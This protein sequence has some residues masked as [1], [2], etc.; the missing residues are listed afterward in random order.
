M[1]FTD[2]TIPTSID[3]T[4]EAASASAAEH[5]KATQAT[6]LKLRAA[7]LGDLDER[8]RLLPAHPLNQRPVKILTQS[9]RDTFL[10][11]CE[12]LV[13]KRPGYCFT[14]DYRVGKS[15]ALL[16]IKEK[17]PQSLPQV[18]V[19]LVSAQDHERVTERVLWGDILTA[20]KLITTGTAQ[21]RQKRLRSAIIG[22]CVQA[23]GNQFALL[24][25]ESQ[26][27]KEREFTCLR[28]LANQL[29]DEDG[30]TLTTVCLGDPR[31]SELSRAFRKTRKDLWARFLM[32]PERFYG[33]RDLT[34]LRFFLAEHDNTKRCEYP[35]G[36]G[37]SY[38]E[39]FLP[40]AYANGWR[41]EKE[42]QNLWDAF[43]RAAGT[44]NREVTEIGMQ[45]VGESVIR[46]LTL[47]ISKDFSEFRA[48][49]SLWDD[50][51]Q[52]SCFTDTLI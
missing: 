34:D 41:L 48:E 3:S 51:V 6:Q 22:A 43:A 19:G 5:P 33:I 9:V 29:R 30:Y 26:N 2:N 28:D 1:N 7:V 37:I 23:G 47:A 15:T 50:A 39:F 31:L 25:D 32:K 14:A 10:E 12:A 52:L 13:Y 38:T 4:E 40:K 36:S 45:W 35:A 18:A 49:P 42:A 46:F 24:I 8:L 20:F 11:V 17:L 27:Y 16:M 21:D 44:A